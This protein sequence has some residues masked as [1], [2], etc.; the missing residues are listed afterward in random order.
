MTNEFNPFT[1]LTFPSGTRL[2]KD[3]DAEVFYLVEVKKE[4]ETKEEETKEDEFKLSKEQMKCIQQ[5]LDKRLIEEY[6]PSIKDKLKGG[7]TI[8]ET[9]TSTKASEET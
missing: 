1:L 6:F 8:E 9:K 7:D 3:P 5:Y 4:E 2:V